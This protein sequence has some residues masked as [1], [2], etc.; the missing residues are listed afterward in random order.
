[1]QVKTLKP[2][3]AGLYTMQPIFLI[4]QQIGNITFLKYLV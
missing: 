1:M 3:K 2:S 4:K